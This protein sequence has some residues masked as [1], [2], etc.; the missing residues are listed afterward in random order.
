MKILIG[1]SNIGKLNEYKRM[2]QT[3]LMDTGKSIEIEF[4]SLRDFDDVC[5]TPDEFGQTY[6]ENAFIKAKAYYDHYKIPVLAD[7][8]GLEV[9]VLDGAPG[10]YSARFGSFST[11]KEK[12]DYL[13]SKLAGNMPA[14]ATFHCTICYYDGKTPQTFVGTCSGHIIDE[15]RGERGFGYDHIFYYDDYQK[16]FA[17]ISLDDKNRISHRGRAFS[18]FMYSMIES[19]H[20]KSIREEITKKLENVYHTSNVGIVSRIPE[21]MSNYTYKC[22]VNDDYKVVRYSNDPKEVFVNRQYE[23]NALEVYKTIFGDNYFE[24]LEDSGLMITKFYDG[25]CLK[26][27]ELNETDLIDVCAILKR[28]HSYKVNSQELFVNPVARYLEYER[29]LVEMGFVFNDRYL[30]AKEKLFC[31]LSSLG[32]RPNCFIHGDSQRSNFVKG[33]L[34]IKIFDFEFAC[35]GDPLMDIA[36]FGNNNIEDAFVLLKYYDVD[37]YEENKKIVEMWI[38]FFALQWF[39]VATIKHLSGASVELNFDFSMIAENYLT[40]ATNILF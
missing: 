14:S 4:L 16:T 3:F 11:D 6:Q 8:T 10:L 17:Q 31:L 26:N 12:R 35:V 39:V 30:Q 7:D 36:C 34:G 22:F 1:T 2:Y 13:R 25:D 19:L 28:L 5:E 21:G 33:R 18:K 23:K 29:H 24:Y 38:A 32:N 9:D 27:I 40:R 15:E 20:E 37:K